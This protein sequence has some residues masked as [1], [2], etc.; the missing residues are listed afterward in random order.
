MKS[1]ILFPILM[2]LVLALSACTAAAT[3]TA[4]PIP[5]AVMP[6]STDINLPVAVNTDTPAAMNTVMPAGTQGAAASLMVGTN[7]SLGS[8]LTDA[9]GMTL[10]L[11][12]NDTPGTAT[13]YDACATNWPPLLISG[14]PVA[15]TGVDAAM[16]GT[17]TR[18]D[19]TTQVTYN[20]WPLYYYARDAKAGDT[21]GEGVG[22][23]WFVI[24]P[25]GSQK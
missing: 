21:N 4:T 2:G 25:E 23:I 24:T 9:N 3:P 19:G 5:P 6:A 17:I 12:T 22:G 7:A 1:K 20:S 11:Y 15:G 13:C 10:Y 8:F 16:L 18:T 14:A